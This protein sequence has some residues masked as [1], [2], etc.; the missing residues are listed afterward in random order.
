MV[1]QDVD[2]GDLVQQ[3]AR[4]YLQP[5]LDVRNALE[6]EGARTPDHP[7]DLIALLEEEFG[8]I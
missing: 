4:N 6:V 3:V 7:D 8:Q 1:T 2:Q 5:V